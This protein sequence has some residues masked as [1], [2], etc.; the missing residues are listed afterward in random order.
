MHDI[1]QPTYTYGP[2]QKKKKT[3]T[4]GVIQNGVHMEWT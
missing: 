4:Y 3:Y 1:L 2:S